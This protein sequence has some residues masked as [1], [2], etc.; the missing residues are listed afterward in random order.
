[1][2]NSLKALIL[3]SAIFNHCRLSYELL[4]TSP[5]TFARISGPYG[6]SNQS[7]GEV[8]PV[9]VTE[10][11]FGAPI[12]PYGYNEYIQQTVPTPTKKCGDFD[13]D[14]LGFPFDLSDQCL[15]WNSTCSGN[16]TEAILK[17]FGVT[18]YQLKRSSCFGNPTE[19]NCGKNLPQVQS[20]LSWMRTTQCLVTMKDWMGTP[21]GASTVSDWSV[22]KGPDFQGKGTNCCG[23]C[24][25]RAQNVDVYYVI[26]VSRSNFPLVRNGSWVLRYVSGGLTPPIVSQRTVLNQ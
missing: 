13:Q 2:S 5:S 12:T 19:A 10:S 7:Q 25:L 14:C 22:Y 23:W 4:Q 16:R 6:F 20:L 17:F 21:Q 3:L 15:L 9:T 26:S 24:D 11:P 1:M 18:E 8:R